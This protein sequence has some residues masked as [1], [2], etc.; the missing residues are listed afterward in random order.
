MYLQGSIGIGWNR[1]LNLGD[2]IKCQQWVKEIGLVVIYAG[3]MDTN[4]L[5]KLAE[6]VDPT[7]T[8]LYIVDRW[9]KDNYDVNYPDYTVRTGFDRFLGAAR[10]HRFR[11]ILHTNLIGVSTYHPVY[12][13]L[14][15]FQFR[16]PWNGNLIGW[17]WDK[18]ESS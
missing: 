2:W 7:K 11:V 15:K 1:H 16:E 17:L 4:V 10:R 9:R 5:D 14:Q 3:L 6:Q 8:L 18:T 12:A 13:D